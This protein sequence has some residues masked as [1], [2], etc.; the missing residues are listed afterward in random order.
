M[1]KLGPWAN[2]DIWALVRGTPDKFL[3]HFSNCTVVVVVLVA[4]VDAATSGVVAADVI[5]DVDVVVFFMLMQLLVPLYIYD[6][7]GCL[8]SHLQCLSGHPLFY[9]TLI[10]ISSNAFLKWFCACIPSPS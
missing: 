3:T 2:S 6:L 9:G 8:R 5:L 10:K 7:V 1:A 4:C